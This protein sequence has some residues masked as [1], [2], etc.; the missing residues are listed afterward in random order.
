MKS[1]LVWCALPVFVL[2]ALVKPDKQTAA[3]AEL[4]RHLFFDTRLS[5]NGK[6]ACSSC[7]MPAFAFADTAQLSLGATGERTLRNAPGL[8]NTRFFKIKAWADTSLTT[9][10]DQMLRPLFATHPTE[11]GLDR[12]SDVVPQQLSRDVVYQKLLRKAY[13]KHRGDM[14]W[15]Q[16]FESIARY[17]DQLVSVGSAYD[18]YRAGDEQALSASAQ[19]GNLL[20]G[21]GRLACASCH[22]PTLMSEGNTETFGAMHNIGLY[23]VDGQGGYPTRDEGLKRATGKPEHMGL[24]RTPSLRNVGLTAPYMHDGTFATLSDVIDMYAA[25][26]RHISEGPDAGDGRLSPISDRRIG[27]FMLTPDEKTDLIAF[28]N[29]LTDTSYLSKPWAKNPWQSL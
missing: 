10:E 2:V 14:Q 12:H 3:K 19:R 29:S 9:Y 15:A 27:G 21:S 20:F 11:M 16:I 6:V 1:W 7:H 23:N 25:G 26:G 17:E 8:L 28:L 4:G 24:F 18:R 5:A 22:T 13:P